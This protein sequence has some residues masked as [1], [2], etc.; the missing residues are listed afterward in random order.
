MKNM[1][2]NVRYGRMLTKLYEPEKNF[3]IMLGVIFLL[4]F[5][6][7]LGG[8]AYSLTPIIFLSLPALHP[9]SLLFLKFYDFLGASGTIY[10]I[11]TEI[12]PEMVRCLGSIIWLV[13]L[14][15]GLVSNHTRMLNTALVCVPLF[16]L[17][18]VLL[19]L[20]NTKSFLLYFL[21][22]C[23]LCAGNIL[24]VHLR[25][26]RFFEGPT[27][28]FALPGLVLCLLLKPLTKRLVLL[29]YRKKSRI[30][31]RYLDAMEKRA[32]K[33]L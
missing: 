16:V 26:Y 10:R 9:S 1:L 33:K 18:G 27:W 22:L 11:E 29:F 5:W 15:S 7:Y 13:A 25:L 4:G 3:K 20:G 32:V 14:I 31:P 24:F 2:A 8:K 30:A 19:I 17:L 21:C 12:Y 6:I 28:C 23:V